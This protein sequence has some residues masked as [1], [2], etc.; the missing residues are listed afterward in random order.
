MDLSHETLRRLSQIDDPLGV[1]TVY[2]NASPD[3]KVQQNRNVG[4]SVRR[5]LQALAAGGA[6]RA[7]GASAERQAALRDRIAALT[8]DDTLFDLTGTGR[9]RAAFAPLSDPRILRLDLQLPLEDGVYLA[10]APF[11]GPLI[12]ALDRGA[13]AGIGTIA[14]EAVRLFDRRMGQIE[15]VHEERYVDS[16]EDAG[17]D[18]GQQRSGGGGSASGKG[19]PQDDLFRRT[20][21]D[22]QRR[23]LRQQAAAIG[24]EADARGWEWLLLAG[25]GRLIA[26]MADAVPGSSRRTVVL[27]ERNLS[28]LGASEIE[29]T[30][31]PE[32]EAARERRQ[33]ELVEQAR[34]AALAAHGRGALGLKDVL[35]ALRVGNV[36]HLLVDQAAAHHGFITEDGEIE[37]ADSLPAD[38]APWGLTAEPRLD[39]RMIEQAL[40]IQA[41]VTPIE[42]AAATMLA[43]VG[44]GIAAI[45]RWNDHGGAGGGPAS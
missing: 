15:Q 40:S 14:R 30:I 28:S 29:R 31:A 12:A 9:G 24:R 8:A 23:F 2:V 27:V 10:D 7:Q 42:G 21:E 6:R 5:E 33:V 39:E 3:Q 45:L 35:A 41:H 11:V 25:E 26:A 34:D 38:R 1:L 36:S 22:D 37:T 16:W 19:I 13:P 44:Q 43:E 18:T 17:N 20:L 32:L 4:A